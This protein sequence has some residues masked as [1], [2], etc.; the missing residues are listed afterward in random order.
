MPAWKQT[1]HWDDVAYRDYRSFV[2]SEAPKLRGNTQMDCADL[3]MSLLIRFAAGKGL[4]LVFA[5]TDDVRYDS[6]REEQV[7]SA[8]FR[9]RTWKSVDEY[10][11]AVTDRLGT[12]ALW[13]KN[14]VGNPLGP[15]PGDLM[16]NF[17]K[18][19]HHTALVFQV[20]LKGNPHPKMADTSVAD[21]PQDTPSQDADEIAIKQPYTEYFRD[22]NEK[23]D[24]HFDYL[25]H[26]S[27]RKTAGAE[28]IYFAKVT[29]MKA[30]FEFRKWSVNV[31]A[32]WQV[33]DGLGLPANVG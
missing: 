29:E 8:L 26:R 3:A 12:E 24:A 5:D 16:I 21:F 27:N 28:L 2:R 19:I 15:E 25:N 31:L 20:W 23:S 17:G 4:P 10:L 9:S 22:R 11:K 7:P 1:S 18:G 13:T 6:R 32:E 30:R 14:T 33:I